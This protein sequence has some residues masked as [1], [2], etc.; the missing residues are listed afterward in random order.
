MDWLLE[1]D[2]QYVLANDA[3]VVYHFLKVREMENFSHYK[4]FHAEFEMETS[5]EK[6][7][8]LETGLDDGDPVQEFKV[9]T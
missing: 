8:F 7:Q 2:V 1:V 6:V 9:Y 3:L 4:Q 5:N